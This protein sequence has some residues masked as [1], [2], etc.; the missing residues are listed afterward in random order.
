[1]KLSEIPKNNLA[2]IK[3]IDIKDKALK[4]HLME[5][6]LVNNTEVKV[7]RYSKNKK[8]ITISFRNYELSLS[9]DILDNIMVTV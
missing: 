1:M 9:K 6:G 8:I 2:R 7:I 3:A 5:M 4:I